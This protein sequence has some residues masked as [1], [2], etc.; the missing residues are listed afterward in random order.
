VLADHTKWGT[1]G[2][3]TIAQLSD[4]SVVI[5]DNGLPR[6]AQETLGSYVADVRLVAPVALHE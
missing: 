1:I 2:M 5:T 4:A 6:R 3:S